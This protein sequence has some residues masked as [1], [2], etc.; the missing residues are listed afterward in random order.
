MGQ[1][2]KLL[3]LLICQLV[4]NATKIESY[5]FILKFVK[6]GGYLLEN[7]H[8]KEQKAL[9]DLLLPFCMLPSYTICSQSIQKLIDLL[10][11]HDPLH[12]ATYAIEL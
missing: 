1:I 7:E 3:T 10:F 5:W 2:R 9:P 12:P 6:C 4:V 11:M 8:R